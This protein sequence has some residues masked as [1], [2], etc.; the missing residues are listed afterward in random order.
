MLSII[1]RSAPSILL[2][3][4]CIP[5]G[6][7]LV[8]GFP[9]NSRKSLLR[10]CL[11]ETLANLNNLS[12]ITTIYLHFGAMKKC[13][14]LTGPSG[15]LCIIACGE[16]LTIS[17]HSVDL[18]ILHSLPPPILSTT[19]RLAI[20][21]WKA[22]NPAEVETDTVSQTLSSMNNLRTLILTKCHDLPFI[23]ALDPEKNAS[24]AV[25]CPNLEKL[26]LYTRSRDGFHIKHLQSVMKKRALRNTPLPSITIVGLDE[27]APE[28]EVVKLKE[29]VT[30]VDYRVD[31]T[32]P[33]W[34]DVGEGDDES[35][36][37]ESDNES[38]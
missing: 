29:H 13:V 32:L 27:L 12:H 37:D 17:R 35:D 8:L 31:D 26:V 33:D 34:D 9:F 10:D 15:G 16:D 30:H 1:A 4:L 5:T 22:P 2:N 25:L 20:S 28:K 36:D 21:K 3:H 19:R 23:L 7:W 38:E 11:P 18:R 24:K 14:R 6:V